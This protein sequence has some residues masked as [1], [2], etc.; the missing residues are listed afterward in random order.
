MDTL[1]GCLHLRSFK[2][3]GLIQDYKTIHSWFISP[4]HR[5]AR[6]KK[7]KFSF[8][9]LCHANS[10]N[11][12]HSCLSCVYFGCWGQHMAD[13]L[14][15]KEQHWLWVDMQYGNIWCAIC[16]DYVHDTEL[17]SISDQLV[18]ASHANLGLGTIY[19]SWKPTAKEVA[20]L[21]LHPE[22]REFSENSKL[23]LRGLI[24]LGNTCFMSCIVQVLYKYPSVIGRLI[25]CQGY[26]QQDAHEFFI[27]LLDLLH[28]HLIYKTNISPSSCTCI[29]DTIFTGKLQSDLVCQV[30]KGVSTT[31]DPFW[32]ISLDLP[33]GT[34]VIPGTPAPGISLQDCLQRFTQPEHLGS[35]AKI[36]C[37]GCNSHQSRFEHSSR[38]HKKIT[39]RVDFPEELDMTP[40]I[41]HA[42]NNGGKKEEYVGAPSNNKYELFG[43]INHIGNLDA[44]HYT[45]YI[46]QHGNLWFHCNDH[47]ILP[48]SMSQ[49]LDSEGYLLFYHKQKLEYS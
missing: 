20:L 36:R 24:N 6:R 38:L 12:L 15:E 8:C 23:G 19:Q 3:Q 37:S 1:E 48:A 41:S 35:G 13:H 11:R 30:C 22:K 5:T 17:K 28:R 25:D 10:G 33:A 29:V 47:Q 32:D 14:K 46:R 9:H 44:G 18:S 2:E 16:K 4:I 26:E 27:A 45:S 34:P 43:V 49:V 42:R 31:I 7:A 39:T 40:F 21:R